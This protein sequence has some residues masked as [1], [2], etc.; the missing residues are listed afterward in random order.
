LSA[1][2]TLAFTLK[3]Q[4]YRDTSLL[5]HFYTRDHGKVR[6]IVKGIRDT[7]ARFGST[8]EPFSLNEILFYKR[9]KGGD[10]HMVTQVELIDIYVDVREDLER[11]GYASYFA[12]L[13][14]ELVEPEHPDEDLFDLMKESLE[15]L[16]TGVSPKR[17]ARIFE[18][19][20]FEILGLMPEIRACVVC[21]AEAPDPAFFSVSLGGI[22][23]KAC[24]QKKGG[25]AGSL[26]V[27]RG[28]IQFIE[29]VRR[30]AVKDLKNVKVVHEVGVELEKILRRFVDH[31]LNSR[32][33]SVVF[34]E[35]M[36]L[37]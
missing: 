5:G 22:R 18:V 26:P 16:G 34:L 15:F 29:H 9:R 35:K 21:R 32:L 37:Y 23:C 1:T 36:G 14:N 28:T 4:D 11:L 8:L 31:H 19:K 33:K 24:T 17:A 10:L 7:R 3:T 25:E 27:S 30:S 20:F 6:G 13:I 12:E 2:K